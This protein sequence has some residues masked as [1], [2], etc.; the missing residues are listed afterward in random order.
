MATEEPNAPFPVTEANVK[1]LIAKPD[2]FDGKTENFLAF[3]RQCRL[4]IRSNKRH[5]S[6]DKS[7]ILLVLS[8]MKSGLASKWAD[9]FVDEAEEPDSS[10]DKSAPGYVPEMTFGTWKD[11]ETRLKESFGNPNQQKEAQKKLHELKQG[12]MTAEEFFQMFDQYRRAAGYQSNHDAY[13]IDLLERNLRYETVATIYNSGS[14]LPTEYEDW[15][16]RALL[17]DGLQRRLKNV[18]RSGWSGQPN[19]PTAGSTSAATTTTTTTTS[20]PVKKTPTGT[21]YG[22]AG[23]PMQIDTSRGPRVCYNCQQ[24]GHIARNCPNPRKERKVNIRGLVQTL[25]RLTVTEQEELKKELEEVEPSKEAGKG[26]D[27]Q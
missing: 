7:K 2:D 26:P 16:S 12:T 27:Q 21:V 14:Q 1:S 10:D 8:H 13:L 24:E 4:Y 6:T 9:N 19:R 23:Q 11:F 20:A 17:I 5:F 25:G 18:G 15:K 22:G 3:Y